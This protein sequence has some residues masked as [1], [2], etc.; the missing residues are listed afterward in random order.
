MISLNLETQTTTEFISQLMQ[1]HQDLQLMYMIR[2]E[3]Y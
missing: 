2:M 1:M 3:I